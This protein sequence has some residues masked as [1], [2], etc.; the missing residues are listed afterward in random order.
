MDLDVIR[1]PLYMNQWGNSYPN[2]I[3]Q[4]KDKVQERSLSRPASSQP[5]FVHLFQ[6]KYKKTG[7][8][9]VNKMVSC[10]PT[11]GRLHYNTAQV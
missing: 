2:F 3:K 6:M 9:D 10:Q 7:A 8:Q 11:L 4:P 1:G 5:A